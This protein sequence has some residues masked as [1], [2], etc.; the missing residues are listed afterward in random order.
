ML[1]AIPCAALTAA[2]LALTAAVW[3]CRTLTRA[4]RHERA[5]ARLTQAAWA[6][7]TEA[8][9]RQRAAAHTQSAAR[10]LRAVREHDV[11]AEA[12]AVI[13]QAL[14]RTTAPDTPRGGACDG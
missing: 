4:L 8:H 11:L 1:Y 9:H 2:L 10:Y 3:R 12:N 7:D 14:A 5:L 6:R 13:D